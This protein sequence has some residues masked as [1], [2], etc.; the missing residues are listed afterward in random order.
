[1][2]R[3]FAVLALVALVAGCSKEPAAPAKQTA[4]AA[5][6]AQASDEM[7]PMENGAYV[8]HETCPGEGGCPWKH[9]R[10]N[11]PVELH[12][13]EDSSSAVVATLQP[14][15]W[16]EALGGETRLV[17]VR[18][19]VRK[20]GHDLKQGDVVFKLGDGGEGSFDVWHR[21]KIVTMMS[22]D[23]DDAV[24]WGGGPAPA[25]GSSMGWWVHVK[26]ETDGVTGWVPKPDGFDCMGPLA[27]DEAC[28]G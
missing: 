5:K 28:K 14:G 26:R 13:S 17:P 24:A 9:W 27:G 23:D 21:G 22:P 12:A 2:N 1:M 25:A 6:P 3:Q 20:A 10:A 7:P 8:N 18:G 15:E 19:V 16:A 11:K 4:Q